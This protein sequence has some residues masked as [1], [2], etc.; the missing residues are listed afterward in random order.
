MTLI[1]VFPAKDGIIIGSDTQVTQGFTR[2]SV[3]KI[4]AFSDNCLWAASGVDTI[5]QPVKDA[6]ENIQNDFP[7]NELHSEI[8]QSIT[9][10]MTNLLRLDMRSQW[11]QQDIDSLLKLHEGEFIFAEYNENKSH[12]V[13]FWNNGSFDVIKN[14]PYAMGSGSLFAFALL[15]KY[16]NESLDSDMASV[17][18]YDVLEEAIS[19]GA[20]GIGLPIEVCKIDNDGITPMDIPTLARSANI[21]REKERDL[22]KNKIWNLELS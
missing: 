8:S 6:V 21:L 7:L 12:I 9:E 17:V 14:R 11:Y 10:C 15:S 19:V 5:I 13:H 1:V 18:V 4:N 16:Q 20:Y 3:S 22:V 2:Y